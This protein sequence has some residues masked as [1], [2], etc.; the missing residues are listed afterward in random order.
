MAFLK[1]EDNFK[2]ASAQ[3]IADVKNSEEKWKNENISS[4]GHGIYL[5]QIQKYA[6]DVKAVHL[7]ALDYKYISHKPDFFFFSFKFELEVL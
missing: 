1:H 3:T 2:Y 4:I 6:S 7:V 5:V